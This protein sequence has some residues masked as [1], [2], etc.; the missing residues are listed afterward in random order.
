MKFVSTSALIVF[1]LLLGGCV[2]S[3][4][5][6]PAD[7]EPFKE[8]II[9][10]IQI[11]ET[12]RDEVME[13]LG[14][15]KAFLM[16]PEIHYYAKSLSMGFQRVVM[17]AVS[18]SGPVG[19]LL[20]RGGLTTLAL[21]IQFD[22]TGIVSSVDRLPEGPCKSTVPCLGYAYFKTDDK[23]YELFLL[24]PEE[25]DAAA[26]QFHPKR[27]SCSVY[28]FT[29][30][31]YG[32]PSRLRLQAT[33]GSSPFPTR[34]LYNGGYQLWHLSPG[35]HRI[36]I[37]AAELI[38]RE[39]IEFGCDAGE[40]K[41]LEFRKSFGLFAGYVAGFQFLD[42]KVGKEEVH[43]RNLIWNYSTVFA[44]ENI[45]WK[46]SRSVSEA[47]SRSAVKKASA[48][49]RRV[50]H[51]TGNS[52][53]SANFHFA[54][55]PKEVTAKRFEPD[56]KH[57]SIY[58]YPV[59]IPVANW[60]GT[61]Y[62]DGKVVTTYL[63]GT[64]GWEGKIRRG[65]EISRIEFGCD[66]GEVKYL[67]FR[68][69][70]GLFA[71][72]VAGFQFLDAKV[73]KEEV[74]QRNLIWNYS[75]VFATEN[76]PWKGSRSVSEAESRSAV[77]KASASARRVLHQTGN[78]KYSANFHFASIPKEVTAKRFEPDPKHCSIYIYPVFIPVANWRGTF[79]LDGKVVTTYLYGTFGWEGKIRR[80]IGFLWF[81]NVPGRHNIEW[82]KISIWGGRRREVR[83][84]F[85]FA[86]KERQITF[87]KGL[88]YLGSFKNTKFQLVSEEEGKRAVRGKVLI[89]HFFP[90]SPGR[91]DN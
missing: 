53:Y 42:A 68:K 84:S 74:H 26:K 77:K 70:F 10:R 30:R 86:C 63:Y 60:R 22:E 78:S 49:A 17:L 13:I 33:L 67:E 71:G 90:E 61:F 11:G 51:Q 89:E 1:T 88:G 62:L 23:A 56:P 8:K 6:I 39:R 14:E 44:T 69:S 81:K 46:G 80:G 82:N 64:F 29:E 18:P 19:P 2:P 54:S 4:L 72:Y 87:L 55:I 41:Y 20:G 34:L 12:S 47:E 52:K 37:V 32:T 59:F 91:N 27:D 31:E 73:G 45:P 48:S 43:Q 65:I 66:A 5:V 24:A 83:K 25:D 76:I 7:E 85:P 40:V 57:C 58:I 35:Q 15:P 38:T 79:Y 16:D 75:T 3:P 21:A 36:Y 9:G 28:L 50:L